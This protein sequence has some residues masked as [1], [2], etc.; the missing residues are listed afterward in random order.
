MVVSYIAV[1]LIGAGVAAAELAS[2]Y[3]DAPIR[4]L[5][6]RPGLTYAGLN[7]LSSVAA[8][9]LIRVFNVKFG[10]THGNELM[11]TR[12]LVAGF[13]ATTFFRTSL[14][15]A[16][17]GNQDVGIGPSTILQTGLSIADR[18][19]DR[20]RARARAE[21]VGKAMKGVSFNDTYGS[22]PAYCFALM[23]NVP[24]EEQTQFAHRVVAPLRDSPM[25]D[26]AKGR[27]LGLA[28]MNIVGPDV[29]KAA[30]ESLVKDPPTDPPAPPQRA[31][32]PESES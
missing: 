23:Q 27:A 18:G 8:L 1:A 6:S 7:A 22:L 28:L 4:A 13:G 25:D 29:L 11:W 2:R 10:G 30:L 15:V 24:E 12:V 9:F 32:A 14:F 17:I 21:A 31:S 16:R 5:S 3:R 26:Q 20:R 19:V